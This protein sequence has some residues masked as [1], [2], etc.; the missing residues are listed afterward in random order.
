MA[1][2]RGQLESDV[3]QLLWAADE[4]LTAK[5]LQAGFGDDAPAVTT[6]LTVL[7]R[8]RRK[9]LVARSDARTNI[10]FTAARSESD[11]AVASMLSSLQSTGDREAVLL[12][13]AGDLDSEDAELLRRALAGRSRRRR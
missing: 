2:D 10:T 3:M 4:P 9:G 5:Q 13:F 7:E 12:R 6:L 1:R 8:L 11:H